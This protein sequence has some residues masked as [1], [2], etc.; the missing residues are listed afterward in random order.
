MNNKYRAYVFQTDKQNR[1]LI[2]FKINNN[3]NQKMVL[4]THLKIPSS[5]IIVILESCLQ[6]R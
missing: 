3:A 1:T 4:V 6:L 5:I 2:H